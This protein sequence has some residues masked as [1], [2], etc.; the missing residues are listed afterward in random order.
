MSARIN[1]SLES[2]S[3][4]G[5]ARQSDSCLP[6]NSYAFCKVATDRLRELQSLQA[7]QARQYQ[8]SEVRMLRDPPTAAGCPFGCGL[9]GIQTFGTWDGGLE[10]FVMIGVNA[11]NTN[12]TANVSEPSTASASR[13]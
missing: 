8:S 6:N 5:K 2:P 4:D 7:N 3:I 13:G 9:L 11:P 10:D 12:S 1:C